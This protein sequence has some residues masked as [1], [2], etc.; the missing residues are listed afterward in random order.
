[1]DII[2]MHNIVK[3]IIKTYVEDEPERFQL[4]DG[5]ID[6]LS[7]PCGHIDAILSEQESGGFLAEIDEETG[8]LLLSI[9]CPEIIARGAVKQELLGVL[10]TASGFSVG[11]TGDDEISM[12][13]VFKGVLTV[14][15]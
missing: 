2:S 1:M 4:N 6:A 11:N 3:A 5:A 8:D 15:E 7:D 10:S 12:T 14:N 13:F 9:S